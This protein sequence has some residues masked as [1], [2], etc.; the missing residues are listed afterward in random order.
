MDCANPSG[1]PLAP[2]SDR[3]HDDTDQHQAD[4]DLLE[5]IQLETDAAT[6][7]HFEPCPGTGF[8]FTAEQQHAINSVLRLAAG[9]ARSKVKELLICGAAGTGKTAVGRGIA[10][11]CK[12]CGFEVLG[13]AYTHNAAQRLQEAAGIDAFTTASA[14]CIK[15]KRENGKQVF[16]HDPMG[17]CRI[18]QADVWIVDECSMLPPEQHAILR[19]L[20][21][22]DQVVVYIGDPEQLTPIVEREASR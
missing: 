3:P 20:A 12:R 14:L 16:R 2:A 18:D 4:A 11:A 15:P 13:M 22:G 6:L 5:Q 8:A 21:G 19:R 17:T 10:D 1:W 9:P 7:A